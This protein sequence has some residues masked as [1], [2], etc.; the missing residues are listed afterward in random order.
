MAIIG[1]KFKCMT[2]S[3]SLHSGQGSSLF[4][5]K[6]QPIFNTI[7]L[8]SKNFCLILIRAFFSFPSL[9]IRNWRPWSDR[10]GRGLHVFYFFFKFEIW[11]RVKWVETWKTEDSNTQ[12]LCACM[13]TLS[14]LMVQHLAWKNLPRHPGSVEPASVLSQV[15][16]Q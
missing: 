10:Q 11:I 13:A 16:K 6:L 4:S 2:C 5:Y 12:T 3:F 14:K 15:S 1:F 9:I 8:A 7:I